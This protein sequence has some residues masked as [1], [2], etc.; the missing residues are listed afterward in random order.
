L[1]F[2]SD[3]ARIK[4][5]FVHNGNNTYKLTHARYAMVPEPSTGDSSATLDPVSTACTAKFI[6]IAP[7]GSVIPIPNEGT[8]VPGSSRT[9]G[10]SR[11][12][13]LG[14]QVRQAI[15]DANWEKKVHY[16]TSFRFLMIR[17]FM[18]P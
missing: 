3:H 9:F 8:D 1:N 12:Q 13:T 17:D 18:I 7:A 14:D 5:P 16:S 15:G 11:D 10:F 4:T 6:K 2:H